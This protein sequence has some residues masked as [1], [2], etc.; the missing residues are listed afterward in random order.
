[1]IYRLEINILSFY[2]KKFTFTSHSHSNNFWNYRIEMTAATETI[3]VVTTAAI[4]VVMTTMTIEVC[5][6]VIVLTF[7]III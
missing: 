3:V 4:V 6:V 7:L 2:L 5:S 1:M